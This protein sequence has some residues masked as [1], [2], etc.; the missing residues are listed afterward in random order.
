MKLQDVNTQLKKSLEA[1]AHRIQ[2]HNLQ[3]LLTLFQ[4]DQKV[5]F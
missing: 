5:F 2:Q 4:H 3:Q 1:L